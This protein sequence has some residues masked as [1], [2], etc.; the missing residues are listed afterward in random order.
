MSVTVWILGD[1]LTPTHPA[2][3]GADRSDTVILMIESSER[4]RQLRY[5]K[6]KLVLIFSAMR[7]FAEELRA[8]G[9]RVD[10]RREQPDFAGAFADHVAEFRPA[11]VK[12]MEPTEYGV[13]DR[14]ASVVGAAGIPFELLP[15]TLFL[16]DRAEFAKQARGKK[17]LLMEAFYRRMRRQTGILMQ[18]DGEPVGGA[19]NFDKENRETPEP[20]HHF[21]PVPLF[22]PDDVT[23]EVM[24]WV[25]R[26]FPDAFGEMEPFGW[27]VTRAD[28]RAVYDDFLEH[29][30][31]RFG[32]YEDAMVSGEYALYH[33]LVSP[34]LNLGLLDPLELARE[35]EA[36]Y[37]A[38]KVRLNSAEG[39]VRQFIG[40]REFIYQLY[41]LKMPEFAEMNFFGDERRLP[42]YYW[43]GDTRMRCLRECVTQLRET[44]HT[45]H[46]QRL[47]VLGN[48][49]LIAGIRPQEVNEWF[50]LGYV[51]AFEWVTL[52]NVIGMT[53]YADGGFLATKPYA[54]SAAYINKMSDYCRGCAYDAKKRHGTGAC[55]FNSLYWDFLDRNREKLG[56]NQRMAMMYATWDRMTEAERSRTLAHAAEV[57][58]GLERL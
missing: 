40:W 18:S 31:D 42:H 45:H 23:R 3:V 51:D 6:Q 25:A 35:A 57:L 46:I 48:F 17:T 2:L 38:G 43:D 9:W 32:P 4:A 50:W 24:N 29:R 56:T 11:R 20:G 13:A 52:P 21:P 14:L 15:T 10:Y 39:I 54:A 5:H 22:P 16:S 49:A 26:E 28:A 19:W 27:A 47:M 12:M 58:S 37:R 36:A 8:D 53:L 30:L 1:Q 55:P 33:S 34:Y 41:W 44:G 7:H